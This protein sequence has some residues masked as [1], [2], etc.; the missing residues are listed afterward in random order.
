[1][2]ADS[3]VGHWLAVLDAV[4]TSP[5]RRSVKPRGIPDAPEAQEAARHAAGL[6]PELARLLGLRIPPPPPPP[7]RP[8]AGRRVMAAGGAAPAV[9]R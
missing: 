5:V 1:M 8:P 3:D 9:G 6:V 4:V 7:R 2:T